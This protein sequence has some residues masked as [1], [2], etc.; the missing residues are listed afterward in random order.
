MADQQSGPKAR[1]FFRVLA[2][3]LAV[4]LLWAAKWFLIE[5]EEKNLWGGCLLLSSALM[6]GGIALTGWLPRHH[7][8]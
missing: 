7:D 3:I 1:P 5:R 4:F 8:E 2:A 6:F